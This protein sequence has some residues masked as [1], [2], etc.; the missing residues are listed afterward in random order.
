MNTQSVSKAERFAK[1]SR[2]LGILSSGLIVLPILI[3]LYARL[4]GRYTDMGSALGIAFGAGFLFWGSLLFGLIGCVTAISALIRNKKAGN[5][6]KIKRI[7]KIGLVLSSLAIVY[8]LIF[9]TYSQLFRPSLS[10]T[11]ETITPVTAIP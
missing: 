5:D 1:T 6:Q 11:F 10:S 7:A 2:I 3:L 8:F 9:L 4:S